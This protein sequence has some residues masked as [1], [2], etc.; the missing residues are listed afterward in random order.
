MASDELETSDG[1]LEETSDEWEG[2]KGDDVEPIGVSELTELC[3]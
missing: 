1:I 2:F 3:S